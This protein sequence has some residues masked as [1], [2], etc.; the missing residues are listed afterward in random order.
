M[1]IDELREEVRALTDLNQ[2]LS[3]RIETFTRRLVRHFDAGP[4]GGKTDH[5]LIG[6][7][8]RRATYRIDEEDGGD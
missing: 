5:R 8:P 2:R 3:E 7:L 6:G 1:T 4:G